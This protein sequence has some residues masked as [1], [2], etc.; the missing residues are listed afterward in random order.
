LIKTIYEIKLTARYR[1]PFICV[2][3]LLKKYYLHCGTIL[4]TQSGQ[5]LSN[6]TIIISKNKIVKVQD[7]F[8]AKATSEDIEIDLKTNTSCRALSTYT[9]IEGE[10]DSNSYMSKYLDNEADIAF[11]AAAVQKL[12]FSWV[13][14]SP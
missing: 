8:I 9:F 12:L 3:A 4:N 10:H 5:E 11:Q 7:G 1:N 13:Y 2:S 6:Q 14:N